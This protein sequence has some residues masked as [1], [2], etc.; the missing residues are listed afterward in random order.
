MRLTRRR[1]EPVPALLLLRSVCH[2]LRPSIA[3]M[4]SL[5]QA[6]DEQTSPD[7]RAEM[8]GLATEHAAH[9]LSVLSEAS[10][11]ATGRID[12]LDP[13]VPLR[14][15]LPAVAATVPDGRL[16]TEVTG[17]AAGWPVHRQHVQ[18]ILGNLVGNAVEHS[19]GPIHLGARLRAGRL[20]LTVADQGGAN[21]RLWHALRRSTP[22]P[23][24]VGLGLW[25]VRHLVAAHGGRISARAGRP[26]L[27]VKVALPR[28]RP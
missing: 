4:S 9:A 11:L 10:A 19:P 3:T 1:S 12:V 16:S 17:A 5:V 28:Y 15:V 27:P 26:G 2:E 25:V 23:Q 21:P 18:Q 20:T 7:R 22:P 13:G 14:Q 24:D 8:A 6:M